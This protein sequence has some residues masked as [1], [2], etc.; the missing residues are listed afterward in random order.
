MVVGTKISLRRLFLKK[1]R[2]IYPCSLK[3][4]FKGMA[5]QYLGMLIALIIAF[6]AFL[7]GLETWR[8]KNYIG[9]WGIAVLAAA[10]VAMPFYTLFL[11]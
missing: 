3:N 10:T 7:F 9:F 11:R 5:M 8:E 2:N 1:W 6:Y 4:K